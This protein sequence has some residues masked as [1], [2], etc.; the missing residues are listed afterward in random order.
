MPFGM[1]PAGWF[2]WPW[3]AQW[4]YPW[5]RAF[6]WPYPPLPKEQEMAMLE[7]RARFLREELERIEARLK[8]LRAEK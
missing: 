8:E 5:Y 7:D 4:W 6:Y 2:M 1:G 3:F